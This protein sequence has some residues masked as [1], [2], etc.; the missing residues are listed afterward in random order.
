[1][2][3][4]IF[5]KNAGI[6]AAALT[7]S[8]IPS[9]SWAVNLAIDDFVSNRPLPAKRNFV[10][11]AVDQKIADVKSKIKDKELAWL[12]ENCFPN[13]LDTTVFTGSKNGKPDTYVIT[14]DIDAMWLR[15]SSAQVWPY[16]PLMKEDKKLQDMI[17]GVINRH[18]FYV[19]IDPYAN[20][21]FNDPNRKGH[22]DQTDMKP[23]V[24]ERK[25]EV[26]SLCYVIRL[27]YGYWKH[28]NDV[29]C[30]DAEWLKAMRLIVTTFKLE[31]RKN[32]KSA[33]N[34]KRTTNRPT[35][36]AAGGGA[37]S[38]I[39]PVG[40]ICSVFRPSDD[41]TVFP[42]L[43][44]SNY[45]AVKSL[46]QLAEIALI[47]NEKEFSIECLAL[48]I[49]VE[50]ALKEYAII[51]HHKAGKILAYEID[52]YGA[53][54][55]IDDSNIPSLISLPYLESISTKDPLYK[56]TRKFL[57]DSNNHPYY[58]VG[59]VAEGTTGPHVGKDMIWPMGIIIRAMTSDNDD[60]IKKC[61]AMLKASHAGTGFM[62]EAFY[63]DDATGF[64]R[65]WFAWANTLFGEMI[66]KIMDEKPYL[67][68]S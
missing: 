4:R 12:F 31:Q 51:N 64:T 29:S 28:S 63:K 22:D 18:A 26:D 38:P 11:L 23:W 66:I 2:K 5:I 59:K 8:Q 35:D 53:Q 14:G 39:N 42:F 47:L 56:R 40:L 54:Y 24:H 27:A 44:P 60:E 10:S 62:H 41:G 1:M 33:Y 20:A 36:T 65:K 19:M 57:F 21:F 16:L 30:F 68:T 45:F 13:T 9:F 49:E 67:L 25:W 3:R 50:N 48:A 52:G 43:I 17:A 7:L 15:D 34:F 37:G 46:K 6:T 61:L 32:G 55:L 58:A